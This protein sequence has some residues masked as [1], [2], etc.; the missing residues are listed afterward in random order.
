MAKFM[1]RSKFVEIKEIPA[2][3]LAGGEWGSLSKQI[4]DEF[5]SCQQT[6][7][8]YKKKLTL[9]Q[10]LYTFIRVRFTLVYVLTFPDDSMKSNILCSL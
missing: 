5:M 6:E 7:E 4:W 1:S 8:T 9:W 2:S 10:Y 3:L